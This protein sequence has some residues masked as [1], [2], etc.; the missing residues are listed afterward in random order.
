MNPE[1]QARTIHSPEELVQALKAGP[2]TP[3]SLAA[4]EEWAA[5]LISAVTRLAL[6]SLIAAAVR[7]ALAEEREA[8]PGRG[9][10][11]PPER[12][13][14]TCRHWRQTS[15]ASEYDTAW[16]ECLKACGEEG[17][18]RVTGTLAFASDHES[19]RADL[20]TA[21]VFGC[22]QYEPRE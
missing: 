8:L 20:L 11:V 5:D 12:H 7:D 18:P 6:A 9:R 21:S 16:G 22:V 15:D 2:P 19:Y 10:P 14:A 1:E 13:C 4:T 17:Y 3:R